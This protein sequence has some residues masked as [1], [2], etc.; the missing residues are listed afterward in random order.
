MES[1]QDG[2]CNYSACAF[3]LVQ[4]HG[5]GYHCTGS[6]VPSCH[7]TPPWCLFRALRVAGCPPVSADKAKG[8]R[9]V[10]YLCSR[11]RK[12]VLTCPEW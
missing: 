8:K 12:E 2:V 5:A 9:K 4:R 1:S 11:E 3:L 10:S 7:P 6:A